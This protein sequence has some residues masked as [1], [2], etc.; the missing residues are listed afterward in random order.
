[1]NFGER[2]GRVFTPLMFAL[3]IMVAVIPPIFFDE[4][5][6]EWLYKGLILL[7]V[8]CSCGLVL[9]VPVAVIAAIGNA[10]KNG[11]LVKGGIYLEAISRIKAIAFD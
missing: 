10:S 5:F 11:I 7:V 6:R 1:Q 4:P 8:S 2:F 3:A 9:S